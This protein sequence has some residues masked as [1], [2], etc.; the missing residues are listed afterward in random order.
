MKD[1]SKRTSGTSMHVWVRRIL[2]KLGWLVGRLVGFKQP[3]KAI[4]LVSENLSIFSG[5]KMR[6]CFK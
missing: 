2:A 6:N 1:R 4:S 3:G 5:G